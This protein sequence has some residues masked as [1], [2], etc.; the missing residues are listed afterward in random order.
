M[1]LKNSKNT[2][3]RYFLN[4]SRDFRGS[5]YLAVFAARV[6]LGGNMYEKD[7]KTN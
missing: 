1:R 6:K 7:D 3:L 2:S 4:L 5:T